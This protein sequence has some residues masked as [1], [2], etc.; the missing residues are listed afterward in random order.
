MAANQGS[1]AGLITSV[2][3]LSIVSV[4]AVIFAFWYAA[5]KRKADQDILDLKKRYTTDIIADASLNSAEVADLK[6]LRTAPD[7]GFTGQT[8]LWD[9]VIGQRNGLIKLV[10]GSDASA[11]NNAATATKNAAAKLA[12]AAETTKLPSTTDDL[13]DA[14]SV[15]ADKVKAQAAAIA[16][17]DAKIDEANK[18]ALEAIRSKE[19]ELATL[20]KKITDISAEFD[21]KSKQLD[22]ERARQAGIV[23]GIQKDR[24]GEKEGQLETLTK[25]DVE[26]SKRDSQVKQLQDQLDKTRARFDRI[27]IGVTDTMIRHPDGVISGF[28]AKDIVY[29]DLGSGK[30]MVPGMTFEVYDKYR[31]MP[32]MDSPDA[33]EQPSGKASIEVLRVLEA[34]S[35]CRVTRKQPGQEIVQGD[36]VINVV[37]DPNVQY[38]IVVYGLFDLDRNGVATESDAGV[39]RRMVTQWGGRLVDAKD[40]SGKI[41]LGVDT[42]FVVIGQE[43]VVPTF[44]DEEL[45]DPINVQKQQTA[46]AELAAYEEVIQQARELHIPFLNQNRFLAFTGQQTAVGR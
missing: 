3:I 27:R 33:P 28:G 4:V 24:E 44:T 15:L 34:S 39:V 10:S 2:V 26:I 8:K 17:R 19:A 21:Q 9:V 32:K 43:P 14:V 23:S 16:D 35:E 30:H 22:E 45:A 46:K 18:S 36:P 29:I 6:A 37:Y 38:G 40:K 42:D 13:A 25:R 11:E 1:R 7:S 31:G 5:E 12:S 41:R 20:S